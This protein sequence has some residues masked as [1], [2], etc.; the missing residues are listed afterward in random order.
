M[1]REQC[2]VWG[3]QVRH[4]VGTMELTLRPRAPILLLCPPAPGTV[5]N[6]QT[7]V[8][9]S[10]EPFSLGIYPIWLLAEQYLPILPAA[11][12]SWY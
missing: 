11:V 6:L 9:G 2:S 10:L 8:P 3:R 7:F 4:G 5:E 12:G 1:I